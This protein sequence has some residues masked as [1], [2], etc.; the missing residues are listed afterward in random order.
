M[1]FHQARPGNPLFLISIAMFVL[2]SY[3]LFVD[4]DNQMLVSNRVVIV[5]LI[6]AIIMWISTERLRNVEGR[7]LGDDPDSIIGFIGETITDIEAHSGG[8]VLV[9]GQLWPARSKE[10]IPAGN[11]VR[12]LRQDGF[13]LT[14]KKA[15]K[16]T[17]PSGK[18]V[19][20]TRSTR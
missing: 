3:F 8:S 16:L 10:P 4:K 15:P 17:R 7:R 19:E 20:K 12:V 6:A 14:V 9:D 1:A 11:T 13:W 2:G 18:P 5:S